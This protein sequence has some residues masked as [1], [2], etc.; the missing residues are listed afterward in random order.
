[1]NEMDSFME[2]NF[3]NL[4][5]CG[6]E[7]YEN[8]SKR[9]VVPQIIGWI[10]FIIALI[11]AL[12][13]LPLESDHVKLFFVLSFLKSSYKSVYQYYRYVFYTLLSWGTV[14]VLLQYNIY[15][16]YMAHLDL[17][18]QLLIAHVKNIET[19]IENGHIRRS[20]DKEIGRRLAVC[21]AHFQ[22]LTE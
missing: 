14:I 18:Y 11:N 8:L 9:A 19:D 6:S 21:V 1:M 12:L 5:C 22:N 10:Q 2:N 4:R 3:W 16:Y 17:Q 15:L 20:Y 7:F 13:F